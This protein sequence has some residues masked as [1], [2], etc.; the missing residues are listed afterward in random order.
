LDDASPAGLGLI[1]EF[2]QGCVLADPQNPAI[3]P[4]EQP[5][6]PY[7]RFLALSVQELTAAVAQLIDAPVSVA[8]AGFVAVDLHDG[9]LI[10]D[11]DTRTLRLVDLDH[12]RP[13]PYVLQDDRQLGST[14]VMAP[15]EFVR[16]ATID[17]R[18]TVFTL[19][20]MALIWL[21]GPRHGPSTRAAF[22]GSDKM[23]AVAS[24]ATEEDPPRRF[25]MVT[26]LRDA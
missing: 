14:S 3:P 13:G 10:Y 9:C 15:E 12:Y 23:F 11:F 4:R 21:G 19:G 6:S 16:G 8:E 24:K 20:R 25:Q 18:T 7:A 17:Q 22:R 5:D 26:E 1:E 2:A